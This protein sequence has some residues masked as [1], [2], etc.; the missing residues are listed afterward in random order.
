[1][2]R[3][4]HKYPWPMAS[5]IKAIHIR[6][7][8]S[9]NNIIRSYFSHPGPSIDKYMPTIFQQTYFNLLQ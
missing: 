1:M 2:Q 4:I 6:A 3:T 9:H 8:Y 7:V 5:K